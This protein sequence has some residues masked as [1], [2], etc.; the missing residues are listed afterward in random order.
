MTLYFQ[1]LFQAQ[2][3]KSTFKAEKP[4]DPR[5]K[6][7]SKFSPTPSPACIHKLSAFGEVMRKSV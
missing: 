5:H 6:N 7:W 1:F 2:L 3:P 4:A